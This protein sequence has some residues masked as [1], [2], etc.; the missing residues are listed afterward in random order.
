MS[1]SFRDR[2]RTISFQKFVVKTLDNIVSTI[3]LGSLLFPFCSSVYSSVNYLFI[4]DYVGVDESG[5]ISLHVMMMGPNVERKF[6]M[7]ITQISCDSEKRA[8]PH[9]LQYL[10]GTHGRFK[11]FNYDF[12][13]VLSSSPVQPAAQ[14][15][16]SPSPSLTSNLLPGFGEGYPNDIDY[17]ICLK[18]EP[19]F[20]SVTYE[21]ATQ[22]SKLL[23]FGIGFYFGGEKK[24]LQGRQIVQQPILQCN[25]DY[26]TI[27]G[28]RIC[29]STIPSFPDGQS[30]VSDIGSGI[31]K[32]ETSTGLVF[33][34][35]L[36]APTLLTDSTPGP[37]L[38]RFVSN[39]AFNAKGF[40]IFFRQNPC[41]WINFTISGNT[42]LD[43]YTELQSL[44]YNFDPLSHP[45]KLKVCKALCISIHVL[46]ETKCIN[47]PSFIPCFPSEDH[48]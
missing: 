47:D 11:S 5:V 45:N 18:K 22:D 16:S 28:I 38:A 2:M 23:P 12:S 34:A 21:L 39:K 35:T 26:L 42:W 40:Y 14:I 27:G 17:M 31:Q 9:C 8:P 46:F 15:P 43:S 32:S 30:F 44:L 29:S 37:F 41:K 36:A 20:C 25:E 19:G 7:T 6:D 33:N 48:G 24:I 13:P 10:T 4:P 3:N 1:L